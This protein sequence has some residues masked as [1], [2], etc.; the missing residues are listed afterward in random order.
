MNIFNLKT[1]VKFQ[2]AVRVNLSAN[3]WQLDTQTH[4]RHTIESVAN[5]LNRRFNDGYNRGM[6]RKGL[7]EF[8]I[9]LMMQFQRYGA[10]NLPV[11]RK[12]NEL[13]DMV[14]PEAEAA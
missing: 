13:L 1:N 3:E 12:L 6:T 4:S 5:Y 11:R 10:S 7:E 2:A 14:Y 9:N 8:V